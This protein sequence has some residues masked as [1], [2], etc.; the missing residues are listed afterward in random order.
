MFETV[1]FDYSNINFK[2]T[3]NLPYWIDKTPNYKVKQESKYKSKLENQKEVNVIEMIQ[4][5]TTFGYT[6][7]L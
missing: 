5:N 7:N 2:N 1:L 6:K 3:K 4:P